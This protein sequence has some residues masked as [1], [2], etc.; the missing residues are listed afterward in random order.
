MPRLVRL[1]AVR[2]GRLLLGSHQHLCVTGRA[3][4]RRR[5]CAGLGWAGPGRRADWCGRARQRRAISC[6]PNGCGLGSSRHHCHRCRQ[7]P[8]HRLDSRRL[9]D[10]HRLHRSCRL[11]NDNGLLSNSRLLDSGNDSHRLVDSHRC[12]DSHRLQLS[13]SGDGHG[14]LG[15]LDEAPR[16]RGPPQLGGSQF[17]LRH[18]VRVLTELRQIF[19]NSRPLDGGHVVQ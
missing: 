6:G 2:R 3:V 19:L 10:S 9:G 7:H 5:R 4:R 12:G 8:H 1:R 16:R 13:R 11:T 17:L 15:G 18:L 14:R